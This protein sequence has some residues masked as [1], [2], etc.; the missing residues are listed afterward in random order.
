MEILI[1]IL[2]IVA[3]IEYLFLYLKKYLIVVPVTKNHRIYVALFGLIVIIPLFNFPGIEPYYALRAL[4]VLVLSFLMVY[5]IFKTNLLSKIFILLN[6]YI[7]V[8]IG[9]LFFSTLMLSINQLTVSLDSVNQS[10][11]YNLSYLL[12]ALLASL[13]F[14]ILD[15]FIIK[16]KIY[17]FFNHKRVLINVVILQIILILNAVSLVG[18]RS[19]PN[20]LAWFNNGVVLNVIAIYFTHAL[21]F[22]LSMNIGYLTSYKFYS[23]TLKNQ[24]D[25][26]INHYKKYEDYMQSLAKF[27][28]DYEKINH[29]ISMIEHKEEINH[30]LE[31]S[32]K[33]MDQITAKYKKYSNHYILDALTLDFES[34]IQKLGVNLPSDLFMPVSFEMTDYDFIKLFYNIYQNIYEALIKVEKINRRLSI[35]HK[36]SNN[37]QIYEFENTT[38]ARNYLFKTNKQNKI[39]HGYGLNI[40]E[41]IVQRYGGMLTKEINEK[42]GEYI[43]LMKIYLPMK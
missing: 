26:Q 34:K 41:E 14:I 31:S 29:A 8:F 42:D 21:I 7:Y 4:I 39:L 23:Q 43:F 5:K 28:H 13:V 38:I 2:S 37:Y 9:F 33:E 20:Y 6:Y 19:I 30:I 32:R 35:K 18:E 15:K 27:R 25:M 16:N 22:I 40:I 10:E 17:G 24:L 12:S 11:F 1:I 3:M 36:I